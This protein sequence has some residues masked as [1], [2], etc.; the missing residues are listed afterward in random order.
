MTA[1][2]LGLLLERRFVSEGYIVNV[3]RSDGFGTPGTV[4]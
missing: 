3:R 2:I 1:H 4:P